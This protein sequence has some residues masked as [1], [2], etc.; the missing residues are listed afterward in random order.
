MMELYREFN[1]PEEQLK[2]MEESG[3][4]ELMNMPLMMGVS[5]AVF[6]GY[7]LWVRR[8]FVAASA[9]QIDS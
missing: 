5:L 3:I 8:Y 9:M 7:M 4:V 6:V 2:L 1:F